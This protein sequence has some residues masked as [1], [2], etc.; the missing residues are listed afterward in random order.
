VSKRSGWHERLSVAATGRGLVGHAGAVLLRRCADKTG[1][2]ATLGGLW[3]RGRGPAWWDR[4]L[5][6]VD[7]AITITLGATCLTDIVLLAHQRPVFGAQPSD[8]TVHRTLAGI[9]DKL[10]NRIAKARAVVRAGSGTCARCAPAGF[11][12]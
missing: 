1:L 12:G 4:G 5:V 9:H 7:L 3:R 8:S 6:L 10:L 2:T 11:R